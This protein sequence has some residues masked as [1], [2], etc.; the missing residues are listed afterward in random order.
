MG[1]DEESVVEG[2]GEKTTPEG[3]AKVEDEAA[4]EKP[5]VAKSLGLSEK[6]SDVVEEVIMKMVEERGLTGEDLD[7][8]QKVQKVS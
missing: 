2:E 3:D 4:E 5:K 6:G 1:D 7:E 8:E